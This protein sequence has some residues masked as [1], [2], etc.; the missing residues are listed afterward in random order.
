MAMTSVDHEV[1]ALS[2]EA[3]YLIEKLVKDHVAD[4]PD[5]AARLFREAKRFIYIVRNDDR[6]LWDMYSLR[7]DEAWHQ[8]VL[9]TDEYTSYCLRFYGDYVPHSPSNAPPPNFPML[10]PPRVPGTFNAFR[11]HY[12]HVF[13]EELPDEWYDERCITPHRRV[14]NDHTG[15]VDVVVVDDEVVLRHGPEDLLAVNALAAPALEFIA[16][17]GAFYV[18]ELPGPLTDEERVGLVSTMVEFGLLRVAS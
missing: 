15:H 10:G 11:E 14:I 17:C 18:R 5:E 4:D 16:N 12:G 9:F 3:P 6:T 1:D 7:I 2:F 8:F 13:G